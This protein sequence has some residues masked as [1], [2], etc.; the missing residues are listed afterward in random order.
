MSFKE[1]W[2]WEISLPNQLDRQV[3]K[4]DHNNHLNSNSTSFKALFYKA[5][6]RRLINITNW[7]FLWFDG[8]DKEENLL[9]TLSI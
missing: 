4:Q 2:K 7:G 6:T 3:L 9:K 8:S 5:L 1:A